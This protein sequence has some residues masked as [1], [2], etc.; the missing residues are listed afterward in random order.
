MERK[1]CPNQ[2]RDD[3]HRNVFVLYLREVRDKKTR[4]EWD[5][6]WKGV[7]GGVTGRLWPQVC[8]G[9]VLAYGELELQ[10]A[11]GP[12]APGA[13][14]KVAP[15]TRL[16]LRTVQGAPPGAEAR[17]K[18]ARKQGSQ[19]ENQGARPRHGPEWRVGVVAV[20]AVWVPWKAR[21]MKDHEGYREL[22]GQGRTAGMTRRGGL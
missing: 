18:A 12:G 16:W 4:G 10:H 20:A 22:K 2:D 6:I 11:G 7:K 9:C 8:W 3:T 19:E 15:G 17:R 14:G 5:G 13:W 1:H 21:G